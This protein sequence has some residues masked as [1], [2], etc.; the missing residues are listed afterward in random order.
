M[1]LPT[2]LRGLWPQAKG[3][4]S[5]D[6]YFINCEDRISVQ[7][8]HIHTARY[9]GVLLEGFLITGKELLSSSRDL[10][11]SVSTVDLT[12]VEAV[13]DVDLRLQGLVFEGHVIEDDRLVV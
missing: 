3:G 11:Y 10:G 8:D 5:S 1:A 9:S 4:D 6:T 2:P 7:V 12:C 13:D